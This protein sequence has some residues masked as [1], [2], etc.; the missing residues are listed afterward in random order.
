M[1]VSTGVQ[2]PLLNDIFNVVS[3]QGL[4]LGGRHVYVLLGVVGFP[5]HSHHGVITGCYLGNL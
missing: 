5:Y 1:F 4:V 2:G 3:D